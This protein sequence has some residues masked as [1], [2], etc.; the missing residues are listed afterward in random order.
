LCDD[1]EKK[2]GGSD[3]GYPGLSFVQKIELRSATEDGHV[4]GGLQVDGVTEATT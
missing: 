1:L 2:K 4:E 3:F